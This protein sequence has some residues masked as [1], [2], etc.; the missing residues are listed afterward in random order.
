MQL[1]H[2]HHRI[3]QLA[4]LASGVHLTEVALLIAIVLLVATLTVGVVG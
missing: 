4:H 2:H 3:S 1:S